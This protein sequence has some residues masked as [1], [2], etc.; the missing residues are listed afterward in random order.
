MRKKWFLKQVVEKLGSKQKGSIRR[1]KALFLDRDGVIN[2]DY[3]HVFERTHFLFIDGIFELARDALAKG[4]LLI[5]ITNQA[6]IGRG[7]YSENQFAKL[8]N[9][10]CEVFSENGASIDKVYF[11]A[12]HPTAGI[13]IYK[14]E[15]SRRKPGPG[16]IY[17]AQRDFKIDLSNS[18]LI[19]DKMT[20]IQAGQAAGVGLNVLVGDHVTK[21]DKSSGSM[22]S[23]SSLREIC[24]LI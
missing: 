19:G 7:M 8:T 10:M 14:R 2:V 11:S 4:Y 5:V 15:D 17:D 23:V 6:G 24:D 3:G 20:D 18:V 16:M 22:C 9:W 13:G 21:K 12:S 1:T